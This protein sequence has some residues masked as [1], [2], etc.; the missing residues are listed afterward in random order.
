MEIWIECSQDLFRGLLLEHAGRILFQNVPYFDVILK[1]HLILLHELYWN[2]KKLCHRGA[3]LA[4]SA[5]V[6]SHKGQYLVKGMLFLVFERMEMLCSV[7][8]CT[9]HMAV[10]LVIMKLDIALKRCYVSVCVFKE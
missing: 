2:A 4:D 9:E 7:D 6:I 8:N 3:D 10:L 5:K 1:E